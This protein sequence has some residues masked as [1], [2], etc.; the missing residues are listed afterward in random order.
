MGDLQ[1]LWSCT[2]R[3]PSSVS[4]ARKRSPDDWVFWDS[5]IGVG[6]HVPKATGGAERQPGCSP[7]RRLRKYRTRGWHDIANFAPTVFSDTGERRL[8]ENLGPY[9]E[10]R[11][12]AKRRRSLSTFRINPHLHIATAFRWW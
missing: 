9:A 8:R 10:I 5:C 7:S 4:K 6:S 12:L 2:L 11:M 3:S 1:T